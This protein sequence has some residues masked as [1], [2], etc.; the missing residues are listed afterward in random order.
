LSVAELDRP[1]PLFGAIT[2]EDMRANELLAKTVMPLVAAACKHSRGKF[3]APM[4]ADGLV[5]GS[6]RLW[7]VMSPPANLDAVVVSYVNGDVFEVLVQGPDARDVFSFLPAL[8]NEARREG[9]ARMRMHGPHYWR[10]YL[11]DG[12]RAPAVVYEKTLEPR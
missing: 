11:P 8:Q 6:Y 9:C 5:D 10:R 4:I 2:L 1:R 12:W 7:G 3:T